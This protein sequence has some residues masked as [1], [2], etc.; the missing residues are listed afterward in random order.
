MFIQLPID[1]RLEVRGTECC[2]LASRGSRGTCCLR[3][4]LASKD[5]IEALKYFGGTVEENWNL[6]VLQASSPEKN[7]T[8]LKLKYISLKF[9]AENGD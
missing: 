5:G 6:D 4:I 8:K 1:S 2:G 7:A 9:P 3:T